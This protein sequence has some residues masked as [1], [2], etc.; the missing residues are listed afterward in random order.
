MR[1]PTP[2]DVLIVG[3]SPV[4]LAFATIL[5]KGGLNVLVVDQSESP[6]EES[7]RTIN[8]STYSAEILKQHG[9]KFNG[10]TTEQ[11]F[12]E[13][14]LSLL[15]HSLCCVIWGTQLSNSSNGKHQLLQEAN[16]QQHITNFVFRLS[17]IEVEKAN[18]EANFR[19]AFILAWRVIGVQ[20]KRFHPYILH[21][22]EAEKLVISEFYQDKKE[23][24]VFNR[25]L[26][27]LNPQKP[28]DLRLTH[29]P[30]NLHLSQQRNLEAGEL[31]PNLP[32]YDE[33]LKQETSLHHW[34]NYQQF[35]LIVIGNVNPQ[36]V[37]NIAKWVQLN[38]NI[39]LFYLPYSKRNDSIFHKLNISESERRT[40]IIRPDK[41]ISM[42]N[43]TVE[44]DIIDNYLRNVLMM[45]ANAE[46]APNS[47]F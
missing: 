41:Y 47:E 40:L 44:T 27:K 36:Y 18:A 45:N 25:W 34:C 20:L 9:Y 24:G 14:S 2:S 33:K 22:F 21:S 6:Q 5:A 37:F 13:Q 4:S 8:L 28:T 23:M 31:L 12:T 19:N 39:K 16:E 3:V 10:N 26:L 43:D 15:A 42:I 32:F 1:I 7:E 38:F 11:D 17:D 35:S 46:K 29:S 30:I